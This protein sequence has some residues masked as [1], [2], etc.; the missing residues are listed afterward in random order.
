[1]QK[2]RD[3]LKQIEHLAAEEKHDADDAHAESE[4]LRTQIEAE[5]EELKKD[6]WLLEKDQ[7]QA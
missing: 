2:L 3:Q 5:E 7:A 1:M 4:R 6:A